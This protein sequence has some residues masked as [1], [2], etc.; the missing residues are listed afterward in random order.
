MSAAPQILTSPGPVADAFMKSTA[1][2]CGIIGPV[3]SGKT[4]AALQKGLRIAAMQGGTRNAQGVVIRRARIGIIRESY[5]SID[6]TILKSWFNIVPREYGKFSGKAPYTHNFAKVLKRDE[7]GQPCDIL[8]VE[9]EFRAIGDQTVEQACRGWEVVAVIVDEADL[10]PPELVAFLTGRVGR[11]QMDPA[12]VKLPTII[13]SLNMPDIDNHAYQLL[14]EQDLSWLSEDD[15]AALAG[16]LQGRKL[17]ERFIQPGGTEP[18]AENLHNLPGG[19]GYY[20]I[21]VAA[22][23]H[24]PGYVDR[25]VHNKP[26]PLMHGLPVNP[27]FAF[28]D[29]VGAVTWDRRCKLIVGVDQGNFCAAVALFRDEY[30][31]VRTCGEVVNT[32]PDGRS[33]LKVGPSFF[34]KK[35]R[36]HLLSKYPGL[37]TDQVRV[38]G[39][40]AMFLASDSPADVQDWRIAFQSALG[41]PV[42]RAKTNKAALRNEAIWKAMAERG[43]YEVDASCKHLIRAH[44]GGYRWQ[45]ET[46][47]TGET[48]GDLTIADTVYTHVADAEQYAALEGEHVVEDVRGRKRQRGGAMLRFDT[49]FD[50]FST[51]PGE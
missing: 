31:R 6:S 23:R 33:L 40:P 9:F 2:I 3:G 5:P 7:D 25:M 38:V 34:G 27:Q 1:F 43:G 49:D 50:I 18:D 47:H 36:A 4:M 20:V 15:K 35:L 29:H 26:V 12:L 17:I 44:S 46:L 24:R 39:D 51:L 19:R 28:R 13:L 32:A 42:H 11:G 41:F 22:N 30:G 45:K 14:V 48:R 16:V 21:Q 10:Q 8:E 37:R